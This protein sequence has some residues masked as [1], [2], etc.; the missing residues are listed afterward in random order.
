MADYPSMLATDDPLPSYAGLAGRYD[1]CRAA[2][3]SLRP[4]WAKFLQNLGPDPSATLKAATESCNRSVLEQDVSMNVYAGDRSDPK[5]WP[6]DVVPHLVASE[7]WAILSDALK[8]RA[9]LFNTLLADLYGPQKYLRNRQI[10]ARLAMAN[11]RFL[12]PC[13]GLGNQPGVFLHHYAVDVARSPDGAWWVLQDRMDAPSGL[14]YALQNR[15]LVRTALP[16]E[17]QAMQ[18]ERISPFFRDFRASLEQ[19]APSPSRHDDPRVVFLT[20]GPANETYFEHAYLARHL[21]YPLV[22]G[23]DLTTRDR[24]VFLRTV[25]GLKK[26]STIVRRVDS[27]FCDPLELNPDSVLGVPGLVNVA[28][29]GRVALSNQ[30]GGSALESASILAFLKPLCQSVLGESL[31]LPSVATWWCGQKAARDYVLENLSALVIKPSFRAR[32]VANT[33]YGPLM[34]ES[35]RGDL[36]DN[37]RAN[38]GEY[39]GQERVFLG[40]TPGWTD[41]A[42]RPVPFVMRLFVAWHDGEYRVM[43]GGLTRFDATGADAIVS[44]QKGSETKDTWVISQDHAQESTMITPP[45]VGAL[46]HKPESTPSRLADHFYWLGRYLERTAQ[47]LWLLDQLGPL[48]KGEVATLDP[49]VTRDSMKLLLTAQQSLPDEDMTLDEMAA[50]ILLDA[51]DIDH[52]GSLA[53][54]LGSLIRV[55]DQVKVNLPPEFWRILRR[56]RSISASGNPLGAPDLGQQLASLEALSSETLTHDTGWHFLKLG[57]RVERA[58]H[59]VWLAD[60][61]LLPVPNE[62]E[63]SMPP[64][65]F[66]L[67]TLLHYTACLFTYRSI[68]HGVFEP[69]SILAWLVAAPE[70]PRSLRYQ[71]D[72]IGE[73]V[74]ALPEE[75]APRAVSGLRAT[76]FRL[77]SNTKLIEPYTLAE[78]R[79]QTQ[80]FFTSAEAILTEF[81]TRLAQIYFSHSETPGRLR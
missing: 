68:Y 79:D 29:A 78:D 51:D 49:V 35:E 59:I 47:L 33:R 70:N 31:K 20:P 2:D 80:E 19:L 64:S 72:K 56:L 13:A 76:A 65:E 46:Y 21:G 62:G 18:V 34:S 4:H 8:Q 5:P 52:A 61:I 39:C 12:R 66:R 27:G 45:E 10:P 40:T 44:L 32:G 26:V 77:T 71:A 7:D 11:P 63:A 1:E 41:G 43:P 24:Q 50:Q 3:G 53:A 73:H 6:L 60:E 9:R 22:E 36:A 81:N 17:F 30:L 37:I 57:L 15:F 54:N 16:Q 69:A 67:Q 75:L 48:L 14:G 38:P 25:G 55:L 74:A 28:H 23:A 42:L 58:R